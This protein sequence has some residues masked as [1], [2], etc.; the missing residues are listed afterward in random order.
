MHTSTSMSFRQYQGLV[1]RLCR[2]MARY[3][4]TKEDAIAMAGRVNLDLSEIHFSNRSIDSWRSIVMHA[5]D[6]EKLQ[7]L[8][9]LAQRDY[10]ESNVI[11]EAVHYFFLESTTAKEQKNINKR[12]V[13]KSLRELLDYLDNSWAGFQAQSS[14]RDRLKNRM[15]RRLKITEEIDIEDF[16]Q[17]YYG[18]MNKYEKRMHR[19]IREYTDY[20]KANN[21]RAL[22]IIEALPGIEDQIKKLKSLKRHLRVWL[23]KYDK[24]FLKEAEMCLLYTNL[25]DRSPFPRGVESEI[26]NFLKKKKK[27]TST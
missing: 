6:A 11:M 18:Q 12:A 14:N 2:E 13:K 26:S 7:E 24:V 21:H 27:R 16:F 15:I 9:G 25:Y 20:I 8:V 4:V 10:P 22:E 5:I 1:S 19:I 17:L 23:H 3:Y